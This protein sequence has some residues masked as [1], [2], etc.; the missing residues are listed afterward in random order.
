M[1]KAL[2]AP[3]VMSFFTN[4]NRAL[5]PDEERA[6]RA[7]VSASDTARA[8]QVATAQRSLDAASVQADAAHARVEHAEA[9]MLNA[10]RL[11]EEAMLQSDRA[12]AMLELANRPDPRVEEQRAL[13]N[14]VRRLP[15]D[16]LSHIL[17]L[18]VQDVVEF[19]N[20]TSRIR[21][22]PYRLSWVSQRWRDAAIS[23]PAIY[24]APHQDPPQR[25]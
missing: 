17:T 12:A 19:P 3:A 13:L 20:T 21:A 22:Q 7:F 6:V 16:I 25:R 1:P 8:A 5:E 10:R 23:T 14:P 9:A 11:L 15:H 2:F 24:L 4:T 18:A